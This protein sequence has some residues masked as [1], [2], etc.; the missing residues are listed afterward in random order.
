MSAAAQS[1]VFERCESPNVTDHML[2]EAARLFS[3][4]YGVWGPLAE[5]KLGRF[6]KRGQSLSRRNRIRMSVNMLQRQCLPADTRNIYV[7]AKV[8]DRLIGNVFASHW[9]YDGQTFCWISQLV[10]DCTFR[11]QGLATKLLLRLREGGTP[12]GF[13]ILSSHPA[14]IS[15][16]LRAFG[17]GLDHVDLETTKKHARDVLRSAPI[18]Y[19]NNATLYGS[20]FEDGPKK[21]GAVS[22]A[23]TNFWVDHQEPRDALAAICKRGI[24]WPF[25]ELME[26]H[27]YLVL[28]KA[29][30]SENLWDG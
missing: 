6:A 15:A 30:S 2:E 27:E 20:L 18:N 13:G 26:G 25:G 11:K 1:L 16:A 12:Q 23:F 3:E 19:V 21:D 22:S 5:E 29:G 4:D 8:E 24:H 7:C 14:A 28:I 10:V 17:N 9:K